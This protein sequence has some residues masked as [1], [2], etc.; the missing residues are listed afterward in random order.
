MSNTLDCELLFEPTT[1]CVCFKPGDTFYY[2]INSIVAVDKIEHVKYDWS[3]SAQCVEF[4]GSRFSFTVEDIGVTVFSTYEAAT[5]SLQSNS[6][7]STS[8]KSSSL[9]PGELELIQSYVRKDISPE[10]VFVFS[11]ELLDNE[12]DSDNDRFT[13]EALE[14]L[15]QMFVG[16]TGCIRKG[17]GKGGYVEI[18][19]CARIFSCVVEPVE[20]RKTS[21]GDDFFKL[22]ARIYILRSKR[23]NA[24]IEAIESGKIDKVYASCSTS[25]TRC[26]I[27]GR[28]VGYCGHTKGKYY[29]YFKHKCYGILEEP[30]DAYDFCIPINSH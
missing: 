23:T 4:E 21:Q 8:V 29:R 30:V 3:V 14:R 19:G 6:V 10:D 12:I 22:K 26:S 2:I 25:R 24:A 27:C 5:K 18:D 13:V 9:R 16:K 11:A 20:G 1:K 7:D 15:S 28:D 17:D